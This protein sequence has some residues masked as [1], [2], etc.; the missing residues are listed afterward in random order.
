MTRRV[1][2][3]A[4]IV[5]ELRA[6]DY[7]VN[8]R[9]TYFSCRACYLPRAK[10]PMRRGSQPGKSGVAAPLATNSSMVKMLVQLGA[11]RDF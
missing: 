6:T 4:T 5:S 1:I 2:H 7:R 11:S 8:M 3:F 10:H 9:L